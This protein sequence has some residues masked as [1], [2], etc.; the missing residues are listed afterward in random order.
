MK[1]KREEIVIL[2]GIASLIGSAYVMKLV[3]NLTK[4]IDEQP[5]A[6]TGEGTIFDDP[7]AHI[8]D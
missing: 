6:A 5:K 4:K 1:M 3:T 7:D 8:R 2:I